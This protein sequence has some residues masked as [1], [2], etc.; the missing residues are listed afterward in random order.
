MAS[1]TTFTD[2][3]LTFGPRGQIDATPATVSRHPSPGT[4]SDVGQYRRTNGQLRYEQVAVIDDDT[5]EAA[6]RWL[7][8]MLML[9]V[10]LV[11]AGVIAGFVRPQSN[12]AVLVPI[13]VGVWLTVGAIERKRGA[14]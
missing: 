4:V 2:A 13:G 9:A 6:P 11:V 1:D 5:T 12:A 3:R 10:L 14:A 7:L 8:A